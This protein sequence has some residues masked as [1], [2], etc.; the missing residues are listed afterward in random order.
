MSSCNLHKA[1]LK[2]TCERTLIAI[3]SQPPPTIFRRWSHLVPLPCFPFNRCS[4]KACCHP[5]FLTLLLFSCQV[6]S[7]SL[8]PRGLQHT[9]PPCPSPSPRVCPSSCPFNQRYHPTISSSVILFS[10]RLQSFPAS[11]SFPMSQLFA[12]GSQSTG[13]SASASVLPMSIQ[14]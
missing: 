1:W 11:G 13:A 12:S 5:V 6:V 9:R 14:G 3:V 8:R 4:F 10:F 7:D 2:P